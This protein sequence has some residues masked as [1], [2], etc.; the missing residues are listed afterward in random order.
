MTFGRFEVHMTFRS[1]HDI[2]ALRGHMT[3]R[4][5]HDL[6]ALRGPYDLWALNM[7]FGSRHDLLGFA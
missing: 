6:W 3:F 1:L 5:P 2:W 4:S 7:V